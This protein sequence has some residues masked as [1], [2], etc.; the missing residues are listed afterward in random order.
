MIA[1]IL[2]FLTLAQSIAGGATVQ[3]L[4]AELLSHDSA[5]LTLGRWC[6]ARHLADPPT[7]AA[8]RVR[9]ANKGADRQARALLGVSPGQ[10]VRYRHVRLTCGAHVLSDADNWYLPARLTADMNRRLDSTDTPFGIVVAPLGVHR[11]TLAARVLFDPS[12]P[13]PAQPFV[14]RHVAVLSSANGVPISVVIER[15]TREVLDGPAGPPA[16]TPPD[17]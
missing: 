5:T 15:Y 14:L 9:G 1:A 12:R 2:G 8:V 13:G 11:R 7:I 6:A 4:N 16:V 3:V 10:A 17:R